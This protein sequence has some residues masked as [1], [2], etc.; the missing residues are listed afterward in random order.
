M[1]LRLCYFYAGFEKFKKIM[2]LNGHPV[3]FFDS[4]VRSFFNKIFEKPP[5]TSEPNKPKRIVLFMLPIS[6][7]HS[8]QIQN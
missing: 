5:T 1:L 6:G 2:F 7:V 3:N 8:V 4:I